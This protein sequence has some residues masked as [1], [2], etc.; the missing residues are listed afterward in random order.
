VPRE[1]PSAPDSL[2]DELAEELAKVRR[3]DVPGPRR[4]RSDREAVLSADVVVG[5]GRKRDRWQ[6]HA[7]NVGLSWG[8]G[9]HPL[10]VPWAAIRHAHVEGEALVICYAWPYV[11]DGEKTIRAEV[12]T[13]SAYLFSEEIE[14]RMRQLRLAGQ[15]STQ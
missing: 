7:T 2:T 1:H 10:V 11:L 15:P 6:L 8:A 14:R 4:R 12:G 3:P 5:H 13:L 9:D